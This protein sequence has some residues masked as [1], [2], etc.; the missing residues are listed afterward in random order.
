[1]HIRMMISNTFVITSETSLAWQVQITVPTLSN[2]SIAIIRQ[3]GSDLAQISINNEL[4]RNKAIAFISSCK[5]NLRAYERTL[6][7]DS[8]LGDE[9]AEF[10]RKRE[11]ALIRLESLSQK[12]IEQNEAYRTDLDDKC[13]NAQDELIQKLQ[14]KKEELN[15]QIKKIE[16]ESEK[17]LEALKKLRQLS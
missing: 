5:E 7:L 10:Y 15:N 3:P 13:D 16:D 4:D 9:L 8:L 17:N 14:S 12:L 11:D 1:M 6:K 2:A